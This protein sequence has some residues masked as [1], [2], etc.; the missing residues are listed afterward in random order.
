MDV[1]LFYQSTKKDA[2]LLKFVSLVEWKASKLPADELAYARSY[3]FEGKLGE[4][5]YLHDAKGAMCTI[6]V[7]SGQDEVD[8]ALAYVVQKLPAGSYFTEKNLTPRAILLWS[9]AQYRFDRYKKHTV[10]PRRLCINNEAKNAVMKEA[11]AV[12]L[13]RDLINT[14]TQ[15]M[16]PVSLAAVAKQMGETFGAE[17]EIIQ[18]KALEKGYPAIHAVGRAATEAPRLICINWG[19]KTDPRVTLV[20]KGVCFDSGG[21][22]IKTANGMRIMKKDMGGAANALGLA[23]LIMDEGLPVRLQVLIPAVENAIGPDAYRPGDIL[24]M[25]NHLTVEIENTDAE[26]RLVMADAL[27]KACEEQPELL[28]DF[29]TLTGAARIAVGTDISALFTNDEQLAA[30]LFTASQETADPIWRLPLYAP[31]L[32]LLDSSIADL[33]N[34]GT[35]SYAGAI[36]AALFLQKFVTSGVKWAHFDMMAWNPSNKPGRPEGGEAMAIRAVAQYLRKW[37]K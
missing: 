1:G 15:D 32:S 33:M 7:G 13:V 10:M 26:G 17:V 34:A 3:G 27:A 20:G 16:G 36:T 8:N 12:F 9:L 37:C 28:F 21:L 35:S 25:R 14:P 11:Q 18:G 29:S 5:V 31:Y 30:D 2:C 6:L 23:Q 4:M 24:H 22:N 19:K